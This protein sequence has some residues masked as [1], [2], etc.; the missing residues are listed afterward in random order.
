MACGGT[1]SPERNVIESFN[2]GARVRSLY[3]SSRLVIE[4]GR[5]E[6]EQYGGRAGRLISVGPL[7]HRGNDVTIVYVRF[8]PPNMNTSVLLSDGSETGF[9]VVPIW[10]RRRL[11]EA[12]LA[13]GFHVTEVRT[14][15]SRS[16]SGVSRVQLTERAGTRQRWTVLAL[17]AVPAMVIAVVL[18]RNEPVLAAGAVLGFAAYLVWVLWQRA[19]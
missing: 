12:L 5:L 7:A 1:L 19:R 18:L 3:G 14:R 13:A 11:R 9:A 4:P 15:F 6:L 8:L 2:V 17:G 10:Q 16:G